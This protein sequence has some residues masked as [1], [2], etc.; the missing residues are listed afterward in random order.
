MLPIHRLC[1]TATKSLFNNHTYTTTNHWCSIDAQ[2]NVLSIQYLLS[3]MIVFIMIWTY[4]SSFWHAE[5]WPCGKAEYSNILA[6]FTLTQLTFMYLA[7]SF[8]APAI[9]LFINR[10]SQAT[11]HHALIIY[12][13]LKPP[14]KIRK[15]A[16]EPLTHSVVLFL[17][18]LIQP[19]V[20]C[21][22]R[23]QHLFSLTVWLAW[24]PNQ[25][26][27]I[28]YGAH[29]PLFRAF[30]ILDTILLLY[31]RFNVCRAVLF[32]V[33]WSIEVPIPV[34]LDFGVRNAFR[35]AIL[36]TFDWM[37][38]DT[39]DS[40]DIQ[41]SSSSSREVHCRQSWW[42][43]RSF[44]QFKCNHTIM[45]KEWLGCV[46]NIFRVRNVSYGGH[47]LVMSARFL[48]GSK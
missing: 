12:L 18:F 34:K 28:W 47:L 27:N 29:I 46:D 45:L 23:H 26:R 31:H 35:Y 2:F 20:N 3:S 13:E 19:D 38:V 32:T 17:H 21:I 44:W 48:L 30:W 40:V 8:I 24:T 15:E 41:Y 1:I 25:S 33:I 36:I 22:D 10:Y 14:V 9:Y 5:N 42:Q 4:W 16:G 37:T 6:L 11:A 39:S 43:R 7:K